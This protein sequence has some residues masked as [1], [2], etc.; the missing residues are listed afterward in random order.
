MG[1]S[2]A[3][4]RKRTRKAEVP[5]VDKAIDPE[6]EGSG[7]TTS[8]SSAAAAMAATPI[9]KSDVIEARVGGDT[10]DETEAQ[11]SALKF[12]ALRRRLSTNVPPLNVRT[13]SSGR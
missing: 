11:R 13:S 10:D 2:P 4:V 12:E 5:R 9:T 7:T 6:P 8:A 3:V 1:A